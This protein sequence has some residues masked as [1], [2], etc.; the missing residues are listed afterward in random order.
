MFMTLY[1]KCLLNRSRKSERLMDEN[2][3]LQKDSFPRL[4]RLVDA[5]LALYLR[6]GR[7]DHVVLAQALTEGLSGLRGIVFNPG[8]LA[9]QKE[10]H[11][12]AGRRRIEGILDTRMLELA[13]P[14][15]P[16]ELS[17]VGWA[18]A[19]RKT[20]IELKAAAG[21]EA[22]QAIAD[23]VMANG[24]S[25]VLAP[26]HYLAA[27]ARDSWMSA[28]SSMVKA[29]R[30]SLD[31]SGG[32]DIPI[33]Y[34]LALPSAAFRDFSHRKEILSTLKDLP[35]D[36][37]WLRVHPFGTSTSGPIA[38]KGYIAACQELHALRIPL[39]A[40]RSGAIGIALLAF[41]AVGGIESGITTGET[42]DAARF[43]K[44][45]KTTRKPFLAPPR[46]YL[47]ELATFLPVKEARKFFD[48]RR[49]KTSFGCRERCCP[50][51]LVDMLTDPRRHFVVTR[52][53]E[54][55]RVS[56]VPSTLRRQ[57]YLEEVLRPATDLALQASQ[58]FPAL[59]KHRIR[60]ESWRGTLGAVARENPLKSRSEPP[61]GRRI[62]SRTR[63]SA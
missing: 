7:N 28:D 51:G 49:M 29:L 24:F 6:P 9:I 46:V 14:T 3:T 15:C 25:A 31:A 32:R 55:A 60:L 45:P 27:G 54:V 1:Y 23:C 35:I 34:P 41:G 10:L 5:P 61:D 59:D 16:A 2:G 26:T 42:F 58:V 4:L 50:R 40:E 38:L 57:I 12:E 36:S 47:K 39:V 8:R 22:A 52:T 53:R 56:S 18:T 37:L 20:A 19:G 13:A 44:V 33:Y 21:R 43:I 30:D 11:D 62:G 48:L 17:S 63:V